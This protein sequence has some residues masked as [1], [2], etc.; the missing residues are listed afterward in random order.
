M[1][2]LNAQAGSIFLLDEEKKELSLEIMK[3][4]S[5]SSFVG[6]KQKLGEGVAGIVASNKL[7]FLVKD[8]RKEKQF[9][10]KNNN[11][12]THSFISIPLI[13]KNKV[14]GVV[15]ITE[16]ASGKP[17]NSEDVNLLVNMWENFTTFMESFHH[18]IQELKKQIEI[19]DKLSSLGKIAGGLIHELS[20][21]LDGVIRYINLSLQYLEENSVIIEYLKEAK[22]GLTRITKII[23]SLLGFTY[24]S[25][26]SLHKQI[27]INEALEDAIFMLKPQIISNNIEVKKNFAEN[28]PWIE[29]KGLKLVFTNL[30]KN[31]CDALSPTGGIIEV[32]TE[33]KDGIIEI[34]VK[35]NGEGIS[36]DIR[37]RI[38]EPFFTT[39]EMGKGSGLG[40]A[41]CY[42]IIQRYKGKI[43]VDGEEGKGATFIVQLPLNNN[44]L[45]KDE[46]SDSFCSSR[47]KYKDNNISLPVKVEN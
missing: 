30:L 16:R 21:P 39:K 47:Q 18:K 19:S 3:N 42:S 20:N 13:L 5:K 23:R 29:D 27:G 2:A 15:N 35:D 8:V 31:A 10:F 44:F 6:I 46:L 7:P 41:I 38:F 17:F 40:L 32:S 43:S 24:S 1:E 37:E 11:Y 14:I 22:E 28:L 4:P 45:P 33:R 9:P 26:S 34:R 12:R 25:S 36:E